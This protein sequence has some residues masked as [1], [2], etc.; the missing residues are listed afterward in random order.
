MSEENEAE[1]GTPSGD[2]AKDQPQT[3]ELANIPESPTSLD[4]ANDAIATAPKATTAPEPKSK[5]G[6]TKV[7]MM[8]IGIVALVALTIGGTILVQGLLKADEPDS[9]QSETQKPGDSTE[10]SPEEQAKQ[11]EIRALLLDLPRRDANDPLALGSVDAPV[12]LIGYADYRC[13]YCVRFG[14]ETMP[15]IISEY[16][17]KGLVRIEWRDATLFGD[18]SVEA[19]IYAQ[20][21]A[22]Q[23]KYW[24]YHN[25]ILEIA[26][27]EGRADLTSEVLYNLAVQVGVADLEKF[28]ADVASDETVAKVQADYVEAT[29]YL[30]INSTP[31]FVVGGIAFAGAQPIEVFREVINA[32]LELAKKK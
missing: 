11:D 23:G 21:A 30:G 9:G 8:L 17:D 22:N 3:P 24:E 6:S 27:L 7:A 25:A 20:A 26:P 4:A 14:K 1:L 12:V 5:L 13:P 2:S 18:Q 16:V 32:E 31:S 29:Q 19:A 28:K 10:L 15:T